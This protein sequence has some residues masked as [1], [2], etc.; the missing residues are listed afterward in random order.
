ML[1]IFEVFQWTSIALKSHIQNP[2]RVYKT[3]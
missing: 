1:P 3:F 2:E